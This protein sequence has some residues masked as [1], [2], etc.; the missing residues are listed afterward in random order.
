MSAKPK[1]GHVIFYDK[2][3]PPL[4]A[5]DYELL[6]EQKINITEVKT[7]D[8]LEAGDSIDKGASKKLPPEQSYPFKVAGPR[9]IL[10][11][12]EIHAAYPPPN[13]D[14]SFEGRLP[15]VVLKRRTLPWE[16]SAESTAENSDTPWLML[17]LFDE[18]EVNL[19]D[20]P[21]CT[22]GSVLNHCP[23]G[24]LPE[25]SNYAPNEFAKELDEK[26]LN[27][28]CLGIEVEK[29][30][31]EKVAPTAEELK[32]LTHVRQVNT[33]DKEL[34]GQDKDGWFSVITGNR[35]PTSGKKYVA[36]L[37]S[38]ENQIDLLPDDAGNVLTTPRGAGYCV[39][40]EMARRVEVLRH[41][42]AQRSDVGRSAIG[43]SALRSSENINSGG[44]ILGNNI[45][46][47][48]ADT[49]APAENI[50]FNEADISSS[51]PEY[52]AAVSLDASVSVG[53]FGYDSNNN[54]MFLPKPTVK[55]VCLAR[56]T[57][58]CIGKGDFQ[59][60][61]EALPE[62]GGIGMF[63]MNPDQTTNSA[64]TPRSRYRVALDS[65][66][67]PLKHLTRAGEKKTSFYRGPFVPAGVDRNL[68]EGPYHNADQA[69]R[70][71]PLTGIENVG[72]AAAFEVGRLMALADSRFALELLKWRRA[73]HRCVH[74]SLLI[75][76]IKSRV[77]DIFENYDF[78]RFIEHHR[79]I[80][81]LL[82][83][84]GPKIL[85]EDMLGVL[86]DPAGLAMFEDIM[87]GLNMDSVME[88]LQINEA[89]ASD[90]FG[91]EMD[92][93]AL[94]G[95]ILGSVGAIEESGFNAEI[96]AVDMSFGQ[97][98]ENIG[99]ELGHMDVK[100]ENLLNKF[101]GIKF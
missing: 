22:V 36:C 71:D 35:M 73:G 94:Q 29:E 52:S 15:C 77:E 30:I 13:A 12:Q 69:R 61:M 41:L 11:P 80:Q 79:L 51:P 64:T 46:L 60:L 84:I 39:S 18:D 93:G 56:W 70:V 59:G 65:G 74:N 67:V 42:E 63:G 33:E 78:G 75:N 14:G 88:A 43:N 34:L 9:F 68:S 101:T 95:G 24:Y 40:A 26:E 55:L 21:Q 66:H 4:E 38:I 72:Y 81:E 90:L 85:T 20:P 97:V 49:S 53:Q 2:C 83:P 23:A 28:P 76:C 48:N 7:D 45:S 47:I 50:H 5:G 99:S 91:R 62:A 25:V 98:L 44:T 10:E 87:P 37:V 54:M 57:F 58:Q 16:R 96:E 31:F 27:K 89:V 1:K 86:R 17:L 82:D 32:L 100:H 19:L 6:V 8:T 92:T 3:P